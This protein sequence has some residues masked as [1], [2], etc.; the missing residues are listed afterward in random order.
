MGRFLVGVDHIDEYNS[1]P[2]TAVCA[3]RVDEVVLD[4]WDF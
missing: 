4:L 2:G 1:S 3:Q